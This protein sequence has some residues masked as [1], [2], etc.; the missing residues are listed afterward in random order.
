[1]TSVFKDCC[2]LLSCLLVFPG[3]VSAW[4]C[5]CVIGGPAGA[6]MGM[7]ASLSQRTLGDTHLLHPLSL[8]SA[9]TEAWERQVLQPVWGLWRQKTTAD[10]EAVPGCSIHAEMWDDTNMLIFLSCTCV[11]EGNIGAAVTFS[12]WEHMEGNRLLLITSR[13]HADSNLCDV[14]CMTSMLGFR[15]VYKNV[16]MHCKNTGLPFF[17]FKWS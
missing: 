9:F 13:E 11:C 12:L 8:Y 1:M 4:A 17:F 3:L 16:I 10:R 7:T 15:K 5:L 2:R 14:K 6:V